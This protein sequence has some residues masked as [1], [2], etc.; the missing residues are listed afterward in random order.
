MVRPSLFGLGA[1]YFA[2][3]AWAACDSA[4]L[5]STAKNWDFFVRT[6]DL[7]KFDNLNHYMA[8][9]ENDIQRNISKGVASEGLQV[10]AN[11]VFYDTTWCRFFSEHVVTNPEYPYI[12]NAQTS[13]ID[14][15]VVEIDVLV[16]QE[17]DFFFNATPTRPSDT[18]R[19]G[20]S[21]RRTSAARGKS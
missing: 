6:G 18:V 19:N 2:G 15:L 13:L 4:K 1:L 7:S 10:S 9:K 8:Y 11:R 3:I 12:L 17:G 21:F 16:T 20:T 5:E 14:N